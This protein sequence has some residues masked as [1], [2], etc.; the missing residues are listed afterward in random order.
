MAV[1]NI[2]AACL[3][4]STPQQQATTSTENAVSSKG[5]LYNENALSLE[6]NGIHTHSHPDDHPLL[7]GSFTLDGYYTSFILPGFR[8]SLH[9]VHFAH[10]RTAGSLCNP[11][12]IAIFYI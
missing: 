12:I 1:Q 3:P 11:E 10:K 7:S 8:L 9:F 4:Y 6:R 2:L 5:S